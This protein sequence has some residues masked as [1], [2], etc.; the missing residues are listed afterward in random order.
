LR[1]DNMQD[2]LGTVTKRKFKTGNRKLKNIKMYEE[3][4]IDELDEKKKKYDDDDDF[5][6][7]DPEKEDDELDDL[8]TDDGKDE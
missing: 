5:E 2:K 8:P 4:D 1:K 7:E 6:D 3:F